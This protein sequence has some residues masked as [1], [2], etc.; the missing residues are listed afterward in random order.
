MVAQY[1]LGGSI[2]YGLG[3]SIQYGLGGS[4]QYGL[5]GSIQYGLGGSTAVTEETPAP[6]TTAATGDRAA[7]GIV[8]DRRRWLRRL[9]QSETQPREDW[10]RNDSARSVN[11]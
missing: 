4:I 6:L 7:L 9:I 1:G 11:R 10:H 3:G 5:G 2:Q 8:R